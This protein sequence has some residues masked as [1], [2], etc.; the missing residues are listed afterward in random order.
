MTSYSSRIGIPIT[1]AHGSAT[2]GSSGSTRGAIASC[3]YWNCSY[4]STVRLTPNADRRSQFFTSSNIPYNTHFSDEE[5]DEEAH[6][7]EDDEDGELIRIPR[8]DISEFWDC[9]ETSRPVLRPARTFIPRRAD[10]IGEITTA[11]GS[12][13]AQSTSD[14]VAPLLKASPTSNQVNYGGSDSDAYIIG[15][16]RGPTDRSLQRKSLVNL[17]KPYNYKG[18]STYGQTVGLVIWS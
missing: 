6:V 4:W 16:S 15:E 17:R 3:A 2:S 12:Q 18:Q 10:D 5:S 1:H 8:D 7:G 9:N 11:N 14:E 13:L